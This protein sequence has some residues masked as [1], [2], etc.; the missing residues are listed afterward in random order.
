MTLWAERLI[1]R[2]GRSHCWANKSLRRI[3]HVAT[4]VS[5][6]LLVSAH[7][8]ADGQRRA[9]LGGCGLRAR[10]RAIF[11]GV[12]RDRIGGGAG[13][14]RGRGIERRAGDTQRR[15]HV[16]IDS[17]GREA[18][19]GANGSADRDR[20]IEVAQRQVS[21]AGACRGAINL[22]PGGGRGVVESARQV[23]GGIE[24]TVGGARIVGNPIARSNYGCRRKPSALS[25]G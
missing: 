4:S 10:C 9:D 14:Q 7:A 15:V 3:P 2:S 25:P 1:A 23:G 20:A 12:P 19:R 11:T 13:D 18:Q 24:G 6:G 16:V 8:I 17:S 21:A 22:N 5:D